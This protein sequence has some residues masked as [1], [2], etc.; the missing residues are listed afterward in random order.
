MRDNV[1]IAPD[2]APEN[3][4]PPF[5]PQHP[6]A[7]FADDAGYQYKEQI[8]AAARPAIPRS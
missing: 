3:F 4:A 8:Y 7:V 2:G 6:L 5:D 1:V